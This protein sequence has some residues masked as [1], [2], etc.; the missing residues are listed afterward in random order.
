MGL[1]HRSI[2]LA[3]SPKRHEQPHNQ[4]NPHNLN[5]MK[6][7]KLGMVGGG[8]GSF[9]G[10]VHRNAAWLDG[11]FELTAGAFS[12][13]PER[14]KTSGAELGIA[15][16]RVYS[17]YREMIEI[18]SQMDPEERI[19]AV[20]IV[21]PNHVHFEPAMM[22][23]EHGFHV[24]ID[25]P[26]AFDVDEAVKL[27][28]KVN[29]T[30]NI[31]GLTHTYTGYPMIKE[32][33]H[34]IAAGEIGA[35]RKIFV[36]YPQGWLST[37]LEKD[38]HKQASWRTDPS[39]SGAG[40]S[41]GDIGTH[42]ANLAEYLSGLMITEI[43]AELNIVVD[44]RLLDDDASALLHFENG[45][46]GVLI[47][48]QVAAGV[49]NNLSIRVYG[50]HGGFEWSHTDP[51]TLIHRRNEGPD[52]I[53]RAGTEY[54]CEDAQRATRLPAGHPEGYIEAFANIYLE[55]ARA[56]RDH[57]EMGYKDGEYD[58][59]GA[60]DGVRGMAFVQTMIE[61][62]RSKEKWTPFQLP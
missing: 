18:E 61:S 8:S 43:C 1:H 55:I 4:R 28:D 37:F 36:E 32:A 31:L 11:A 57:E 33:R 50:E 59:P 58:F 20:A 39:R 42:A 54:L 22:A 62:A 46:T 45:V 7:I 56:I 9:I 38:G 60:E 26:I 35:L 6:K 13:N 44:G 34:R 3:S 5:A 21:T 19:H 41:V 30:G 12:S 15:P 49:E 17:S 24:I 47:A 16:E 2:I 29:E 51:N 23:L 25:K 10:A 40:G 27:R 53:L 14:S 48:T 52:Q